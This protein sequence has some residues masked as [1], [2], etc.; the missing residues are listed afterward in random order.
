MMQQEIDLLIEK[1]QHAKT[2]DE[3]FWMYS[4]L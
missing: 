3:R 2:F 1:K 4:I